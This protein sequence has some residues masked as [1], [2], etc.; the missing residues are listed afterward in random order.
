MEVV[1]TNRSKASFKRLNNKHLKEASGAKAKQAEN[2]NETKRSIVG[3]HGESR[4]C[5][6]VRGG[7]ASFLKKA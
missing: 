6:V 4:I 3:Q 2:K 1:D 5:A 7:F